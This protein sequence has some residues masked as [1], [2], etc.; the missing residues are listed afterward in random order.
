[1][2]VCEVPSPKSKYADVISLSASLPAHNRA[3]DWGI[4][5]LVDGSSLS[6]VQT[7]ERVLLLFVS[8]LVLEGEGDGEGE[9]VMLP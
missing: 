1:M 6:E 8:E 3:T 5:L 2:I 9:L 4:W 7:G